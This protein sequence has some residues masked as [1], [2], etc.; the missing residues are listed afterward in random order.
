MWLYLLQINMG[1]LRWVKKY[2]NLGKQ[3]G[4]NTKNVY[5]LVFFREK[6]GEETSRETLARNHIAGFSSWLR[7]LNAIT[8]CLTQ[9]TCKCKQVSAICYR[10]NLAS[11][12][13]II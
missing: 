10:N 4:I 2:I 8:L 1:Y 11:Y 13:N 3:P 5:S 6:K 12:K 7:P 9:L